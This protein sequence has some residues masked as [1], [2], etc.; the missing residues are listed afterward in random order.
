MNRGKPPSIEGAGCPFNER[1]GRPL[2]L[3]FV[4]WLWYVRAP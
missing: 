3:L 1:R 4:V 2:S